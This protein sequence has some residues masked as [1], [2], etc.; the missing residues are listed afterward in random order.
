MTYRGLKPAT[1]HLAGVASCGQSKRGTSTSLV[2]RYNL[3]IKFGLGSNTPKT[4]SIFIYI[5]TYSRLLPPSWKW[6]MPKT[7]F[8]A[9]Y[10]KDSFHNN[11]PLL[12]LPEKGVNS[13]NFR[14]VF[15]SNCG[16]DCFNPA[17]WEST[18]LN[19]GF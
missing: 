7:F 17:S 12:R 2:L 13:L 8:H 15:N 19:S 10:W 4:H 18:A 9:T 1:S 14:F 11:L 3:I 6:N 5:Y 16:F